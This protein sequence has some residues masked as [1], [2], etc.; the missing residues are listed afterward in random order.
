MEERNSKP[1]QSVPDVKRAFMDLLREMGMD[2]ETIKIISKLPGYKVQTLVALYQAY[3]Y[4]QDFVKEKAR[5]FLERDLKK[6]SVREMLNREE[7]RPLWDK[8]SDE[9]SKKRFIDFAIRYYQKMLI[10]EFSKTLMHEYMNTL[11]SSFDKTLFVVSSE[12]D[13][14]TL[15]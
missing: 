10:L 7:N 3:T 12:P 14:V 11:G 8:D 6:E 2:P 15:V 5:Q 9:E 4:R 1:T 13:E